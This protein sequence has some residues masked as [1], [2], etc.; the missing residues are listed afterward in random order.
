MKRLL[1]FLCLV[2]AAV[3]TLIPP[4]VVP[5]G[6][7]NDIAAVQTHTKEPVGPLLHSWGPTLQSLR[8][9]PRRS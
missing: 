3:Y 5:E 1:L 8:A 2:G 4:R 6:E 7:V 9:D